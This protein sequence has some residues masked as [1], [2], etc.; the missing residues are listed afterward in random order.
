V[1][2]ADLKRGRFGLGVHRAALFGV[3]YR[4][5]LA[6]GI[7][8][9]TGAEVGRLD[10]QGEKPVLAAA[11]GRQLGRFDLVVDASGARSKLKIATGYLPEPRPLPYGA[12]WTTLA[13]RGEGFDPHTLSQRYR[14]S[15]V[16]VWV[17]PTGRA[18]I[19]GPELATL[20]WSLK[21]AD[22]EA[23]RAAGI[24]AWKDQ[25][26]RLWPECQ[27][28]LDQI[29]DFGQLTL[30]RYGHHTLKPP[31]GRGLAVVGDAAHS[32]SP[33]LAQGANMALLDAAAL[34]HALGSCR[35]L[36]EALV[37][38]ARARRS[39]I[40]LFQVLSRLFTPFY[41]SDSALLPLFRDRVVS[42][43]SRVPPNPRFLAAMVCGTL[44][45]PFARLGLAEAEWGKIPQGLL[46]KAET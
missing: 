3:L 2:Y 5:V 22:A 28:Y 19:G 4:A 44:V 25:V 33:I 1:R 27:P 46:Y 21:I 20:L 36:D 37:A 17:L 6:E 9:E 39:H 26:R 31:V 18:A 34:A 42:V 13:W 7:A 45:D 14:R 38:Y 15:S 10:N 41:Q 29:E 30:A 8:I 43:L 16:L 12:F 11:D 35:S 23:I 24:G 40:R 32:T